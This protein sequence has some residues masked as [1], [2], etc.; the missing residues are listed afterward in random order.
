MSGPTPSQTIGPFF[1]E[2]T[3]W[4]TG[5][6]GVPADWVSVSG[7][8]LDLD[9]K[10]VRDAML[11]ISPPAGTNAPVQR[12]FSGDDGSFRFRMPRA[13]PA[14]VTVFARGLLRHLFTRVY[15][16]PAAVPASVPAARRATLTAAPEGESW[17]WDL[18][19]RGEGETVF[20]DLG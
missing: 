6:T 5:D 12:V 15:L 16:D 19:L 11:E 8:V 14:L 18:R 10:P 2:A 3:R 20:F 9:G 17:R 4:M 7:R 1:H 13:Q